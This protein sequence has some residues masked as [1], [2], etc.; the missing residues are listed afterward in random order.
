MEPVTATFLAFYEDEFARDRISQLDEHVWNKRHLR[1][2]IVSHAR[3]PNPL[4]SNR[5][6]IQPPYCYFR[7]TEGIYPTRANLLVDRI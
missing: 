7:G 1:E 3:L 4:V 2:F 5:I 6:E